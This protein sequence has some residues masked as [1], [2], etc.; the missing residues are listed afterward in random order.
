MK[1]KT[2]LYI[3]IVNLKDGKH[4][5][6]FQAGNDL[7]EVFENQIV[8]EGNLDVAVVLDKGG[9]M[10]TLNFQITGVV[11]LTCDRSL[12]TFDEPVN[13]SKKVIYKFA[14]KDEELSDEIITIGHNTNRLMLEQVVFDFVVLSLPLK[15]IH[16]DLRDSELPTSADG[17]YFVVYQSKDEEASEDEDEKIDPR[18]EALKNLK[19]NQN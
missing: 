12:N 1:P 11:K 19:N 2:S 9:H 4:N 13:I 3:D 5:Y 17:Q 10:M 6:R 18:W 16:P 14:E 7:F 15:K 8:K